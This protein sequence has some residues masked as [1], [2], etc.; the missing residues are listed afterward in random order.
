VQIW[1]GYTLIGLKLLL[2]FALAQQ[3][4]AAANFT[5]RSSSQSVKE[6]RD[7]VIISLNNGHAQDALSNLT[8]ADRLL[9]GSIYSGGPGVIR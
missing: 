3:V 4:H 1:L 2:I 5:S 8:L 9:G 7:K 6:L